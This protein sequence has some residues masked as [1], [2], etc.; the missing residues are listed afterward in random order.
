M[1]C[2]PTVELV[3]SKLL[4][5]FCAIVLL[6]SGVVDA[7]QS[8]PA[9]AGK[10]AFRAGAATSNVTPP[11]GLSINGGM[12]NV[13]ARHIH[14]E[15]HARCLALD[16]GQTRLALVV[17]DSCMIPRE[18]FDA[19][20]QKI[21]Q[22]T[23]IPA[24][25]ILM[26]ATHTHSAPASTS[27][28]QSDPDEAYEKFLA[29]RI[30]DGVRRAVN[31][32]APAK[33][34]W[35]FGKVPDQVF[36]RR[37]KMKPGTA[38]KN[39]F[40]GIDQVKMN[41]GVGDLNL[42]EP[43]GPTDPELSIVSVQSADGHPLALLAN[44]SLHYCGGVG[45]GHISADYYGMFADR[46]Q[47]L[48]GADRQDPPFVAMMSNGTSGNINNIN[49]R[50]GQPKQPS[51]GQMRLV[52]KEVADEA[53]RVYK[54]IQHQGW[55]PLGAVQKEIQLGVRLPSTDEVERARQIMAESKTPVMQTLEQI[56][57]RETVLI[58]SYPP[59]VPVILQVLRIGDL[60]IAAIPCEVFVE[61]GLELKQKNPPMFTIELANGYHGYLPTVEHHKLGGYETWRARSS[62]LELEAAP[63]I[64]DT[65]TELF[66]RL[67]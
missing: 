47:Q 50:G 10:A 45:A 33:I 60:R 28:F 20:K 38:L 57:A 8:S 5:K 13:T 1:C 30:A 52:A 36:N 2:N 16:D 22:Q 29:T 34:G 18:I 23:G 41:P 48:L 35:G 17:V 53:G 54:T 9:T 61:I 51:Y 65:M 67:K 58:S 25:H 44:Y 56:Y 7:A 40:G 32:L 27:V 43:A 26:S 66:G 19:A 31:N 63:K 6:A 21:Q 55:V 37:W 15:L 46:V 59:Q 14:D 12:Q 62:Y 49:F 4:A 11:L 39:P 3:G 42:L 24:D 64:V